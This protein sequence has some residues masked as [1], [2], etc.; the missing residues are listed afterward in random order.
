MIRAV[1]QRLLAKRRARLGHEPVESRRFNAMTL[2]DEFDR[3]PDLAP[4]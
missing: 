3:K 4:F 1:W 2:L